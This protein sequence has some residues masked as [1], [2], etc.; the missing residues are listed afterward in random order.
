MAIQ[1]DVD[2]RATVLVVAGAG[3]GD[4]VTGDDHAAL[5]LDRRT[6]R[7]AELEGLG[8]G[9]QRIR[10]GGQAELQ[11]GGLAEN[12]LGLGGVLHA[13]QLDHDAVGALA[14]H[15]RLGH[16]QL[17]DAVADGGEVLLDR[18]FADFR[19][20]GGRHAQAQDLHVVALGLGHL[21]IAEVPGDQ[22]A[23]LVQLLLFGE[24]ELDGAILHRQ[25]AVAQA[26]LAQGALHFALVDLQARIDGLVHVHFEQEVHATGQVQAELHRAGG[27]LAQPV[28]SGLGEVQGDHVVV[29][30]RAADDVLGRQLVFLADQADQRAA[31]ADGAG[32]DGDVGVGQS[33]AGLVHVGLGDAQRGA[34]AADLDGRIVGIKV[35]R[36]ID[37]ADGENRQDQQILPQGIFV[38]HDTARL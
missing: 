13:G 18:V 9:A 20:L 38:E 29:A 25:A 3:I 30:Q 35:G 21:E 5:Q 37:E 17:V 27:Q 28:R 12:P 6:A 2:L 31:L 8:G 22:R 26:L 32:L 14:L 1:T 33:L 24:A 15:Q 11:V 19:Q 34:R 7:L 23:G 36:G 4:L 16:T 10:L